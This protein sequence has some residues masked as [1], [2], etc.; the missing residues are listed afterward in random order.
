MVCCEADA[1]PLQEGL[2][3]PGEIARRQERPAAL[4]QAR[5]EIEARA[6]AR[7][8]V[9]LAE[10]EA[11]LAARAARKERGEKAG[12]KPP[13]A[14]RPGPEAKGQSNFTDP[15]SR[16]M[17][18]G[19]GNHFEQSYNAQAAVDVESRL[20][21]G[22]RVSQAPNDKQELVPTPAAIPA[23]AGTLTAA[24]V[25]S[26]FFRESAMHTDRTRRHRP[27]R[28]RGR[29]ED[30]PSPERGR[31]G[32][33]AGIRGSGGGGEHDRSDASSAQDRGGQDAL[34]IAAADGGA[35]LW[36]HQVRAGVPAVWAARAGESVAGMDAGVPG[37]QPETV[38]SAGSRA[39]TGASELKTEGAGTGKKNLARGNPG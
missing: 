37:L 23:E 1:T 5:A 8:T 12:G 39:E 31:F 11:K 9:P 26:G 20:I 16:I 19:S 21:V 30:R 13:Q 22:Q 29:G 27:D 25:D 15:E 32:K 33:E 2:T 28:L 18:A 38:A 24:L 36:D 35:G 7:Y 14:P 17:K 4:A 10:H 34:Q 6:H 3:M